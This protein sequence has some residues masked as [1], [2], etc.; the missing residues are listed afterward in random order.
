MKIRLL[1]AISLLLAFQQLF[2]QQD[3]GLWAMFQDQRMSNAAVTGEYVAPSSMKPDLEAGQHPARF[4]DLAEWLAASIRYPDSGRERG[5]EGRVTMELR[6]SE[7]GAVLEARV[8]HS[9]DPVL[10]QAALA[11]VREMPNWVPASNYGV[12]VR[13]K[14]RIDLDFTLR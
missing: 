1:S 7:S 9:A 3:A 13:S 8:I 12:P 4:P 6:L 11:V 14:T 10:D 5:L 2:A